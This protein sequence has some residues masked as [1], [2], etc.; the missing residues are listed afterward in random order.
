MKKENKK[1]EL[2]E[3]CKIIF[4]IIIILINVYV[5]DIML[6]AIKLYGTSDGIYGIRFLLYITITVISSSIL[7]KRINFTRK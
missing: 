1:R 4:N 2:K 3:G 5:I 7:L 6:K